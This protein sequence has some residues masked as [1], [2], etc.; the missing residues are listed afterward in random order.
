[1]IPYL[2]VRTHRYSHR[3]AILTFIC[4]PLITRD[5]HSFQFTI[6]RLIDSWYLPLELGKNEFK[7]WQLPIYGYVGPYK[8]S[9]YKIFKN[10]VIFYLWISFPGEEKRDTVWRGSIGSIS[11]CDTFLTAFTT[12]RTTA[13]KFNNHV[14]SDVP[15]RIKEYTFLQRQR[16][17]LE[18]IYYM[19]L[20]F[21]IHTNRSTRDSV[22]RRGH[23]LQYVFARNSHTEGQAL[24]ASVEWFG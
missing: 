13:R 6:V 5:R 17:N 12:I 18:R 14:W 7:A 16:P 4:T 22:V 11:T 19:V 9:S 8:V 15:Q 21:G 24:C 10:G 2:Y 3:G 23:L 1:M 20:S